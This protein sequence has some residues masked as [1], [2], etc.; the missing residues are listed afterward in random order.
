MKCPYCE[1]S[2]KVVDSRDAQDGAAV[3]RRRECLGCAERFT[4]YERVLHAGIDVRKRDGRIEAFRREKLS[5]GLT[6][7]FEK[8]PVPVEALEAIVDEI[9]ED[10]R[11]R[12]EAVVETR[13][14][15]E[16]LCER[17][18]AVDEVAYLRFASVYKEF[19]DSSHFLQEVHKLKV[20]EDQRG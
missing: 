9:E 13:L 14:I 5:M 10:L 16:L 7:A 2:T 6:K 8:R 4:T 11:S 3:R 12:G 15:G 17:I 18:R 19:S 1:D 20:L